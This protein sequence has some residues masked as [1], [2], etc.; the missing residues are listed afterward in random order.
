[1]RHAMRFA[2]VQHTSYNIFFIANVNINDVGG[3]VMLC[4]YMYY[5]TVDMSKLF[6]WPT[7]SL[8]HKTTLETKN[9]QIILM[10]RPLIILAK[11]FC[12]K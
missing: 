11:G 1:M 5:S 4:I 9:I 10:H 6:V 8:A 3:C 7:E 12:V 2:T